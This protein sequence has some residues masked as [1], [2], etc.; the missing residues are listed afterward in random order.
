MSPFLFTMNEKHKLLKVGKKEYKLV[1][2]TQAL[3][4]ITDKYGGVEQM[5]SALEKMGV[6]AV[7]EYAWLIALLANQGI[8]IDNE[9]NGTEIPLITDKKV[10]LCLTPA[11]LMS[12]QSILMGAISEG[13]GQTIDID[14]DNDDNDE[15]LTE[16]KKT[17]GVTGE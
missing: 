8:A 15:V 10:M 1:F 7:Q 6:K 5:A 9:E 16:I 13:M 12:A 11:D 2:S 4:D 17:E 14:G 3:I